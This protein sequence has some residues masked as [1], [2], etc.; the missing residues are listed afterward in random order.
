MIDTL[1]VAHTATLV[2]CI[3]T[4]SSAR[5]VAGSSIRQPIAV[6]GVNA[7]HVHNVA[8][9]ITGT[10]PTAL[11]A[12]IQRIAISIQDKAARFLGA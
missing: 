12:A 8:G 10:G 7:G 2:L 6:F 4:K 1:G 5:T 3:V 9:F 11:T